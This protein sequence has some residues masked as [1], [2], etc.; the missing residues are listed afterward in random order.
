MQESLAVKYAGNYFRI[1]GDQAENDAMWCKCAAGSCAD[2]GNRCAICCAAGSSE[3]DMFQIKV[4][5][6]WRKK[7][8]ANEHATISDVRASPVGEISED[9]GLWKIAGIIE[10][11][12]LS[13]G[14]MAFARIERSKSDHQKTLGYYIAE[15]IFYSDK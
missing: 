10:S 8:A 12:G 11:G 1:S 13:V 2:D 3:F 5:P 15:F 9:G 4:L 6:M 7:I 14:I